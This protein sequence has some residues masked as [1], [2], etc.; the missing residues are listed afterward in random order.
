S[1]DFFTQPSFHLSLFAQK[2]RASSTFCQW[3]HTMHQKL[4][5][6]N[7]FANNL[8]EIVRATHTKPIHEKSSTTFVSIIECN[9]QCLRRS[10][11]NVKG[12]RFV[13]FVQMSNVCII[14]VLEY[15]S[16]LR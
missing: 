10:R 2:Q 3:C 13:K 4:R 16:F 7:A 14:K 12:N 9:L 1:G 6:G 15:M 8:V 5:M 11:I